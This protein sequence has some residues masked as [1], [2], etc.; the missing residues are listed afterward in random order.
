MSFNLP[1]EQKAL[2]DAIAADL[3]PLG[4]ARSSAPAHGGADVGDTIKARRPGVI[5]LDQD[6]TRYFNLHHTPDDT[7]DKVDRAE[8]TQNVEAWTLV[9]RHVGMATGNL[10]PQD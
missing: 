7:L 10:S 6:G 5:D 3:A 9:L 1:P 2:A 4:I 8:L